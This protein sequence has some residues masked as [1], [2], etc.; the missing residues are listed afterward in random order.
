MRSV[1]VV[2]LAHQAPAEWTQYLAQARD[3]FSECR[4]ELEPLVMH[5][6]SIQDAE[7]ALMPYER[8]EQGILKAVLDV[9]RWETNCEWRMNI[10]NLDEM[11]PT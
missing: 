11:F 5:R 6:F 4:E 2:H 1:E 7:Q 3:L 8:R 10:L 9:S